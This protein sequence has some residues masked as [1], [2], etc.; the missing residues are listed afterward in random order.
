MIGR[1][2]DCRLPLAPLSAAGS[3]LLLSR[4]APAIA[5]SAW[6]RSSARSC[7]GLL[8]SCGHGR[9]SSSG[10]VRPLARLPPLAPLLLLVPGVELLWSRSPFP[11]V[12][13]APSAPCDLLPAAP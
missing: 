9:P 8:P 2:R 10:I 11:E 4:P 5:G 3:P 6:R 7:F 12:R 1:N 13:H